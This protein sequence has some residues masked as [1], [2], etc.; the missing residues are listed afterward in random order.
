MYENFVLPISYDH[1]TFNEKFFDEFILH[2]ELLIKFFAEKNSFDTDLIKNK[3]NHAQTGKDIFDWFSHLECDNK[4]LIENELKSVNDIGRKAHTFYLEHIGRNLNIQNYAEFPPAAQA[5]ICL[6]EDEALF[7]KFYN[8]LQIDKASSLKLYRGQTKKEFSLTEMQI[9]QWEEALKSFF[10]EKYEG[11]WVKIHS[12]CYDDLYAFLIIHE[13][14][15]RAEREIDPQDV[16]KFRIRER[17]PIIDKIVIY[18]WGSGIVRISGHPSHAERI[19]N[20]FAEHVAQDETLKNDSSAETINLQIFKQS[21]IV[22]DLLPD[23]KI[24]E[25]KVIC[26]EITLNNEESTIYSIENNEDGIYPFLKK[27]RIEL[28]DCNFRS[29]KLLFKVKVSRGRKDKTVELRLRNYTN[30]DESEKDRT[31]EKILRR[32]GVLLS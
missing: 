7:W 1:Y 9:A 26:V 28:A 8:R 27:R 10:N 25:A 30:L 31:I 3:I 5:L 23:D 6:L 32:W 20:L 22:L 12:Y 24:D 14:N 19:R 13:T 21:N 17:R 16:Q 11:S 18:D 2:K 4:N 29:V 15:L